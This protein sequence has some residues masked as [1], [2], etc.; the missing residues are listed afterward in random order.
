MDGS[1]SH[2][3]TGPPLA[4]ARRLC[5]QA[6]GEHWEVDRRRDAALTEVPDTRWDRR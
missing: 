5:E 6:R 2:R 1:Q 4:D 3:T